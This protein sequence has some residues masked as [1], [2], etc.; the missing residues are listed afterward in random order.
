MRIVHGDNP[1]EIIYVKNI[2]SLFNTACHKIAAIAQVV[3]V[4][5]KTDIFTLNSVEL[6]EEDFVPAEFTTSISVIV[7]LDGSI[8]SRRDRK[9]DT[10]SS[11][12]VK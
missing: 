11:R 10:D 12:G 4:F 6:S 9:D 5:T 7:E 1:C 3:S 2:S 8:L